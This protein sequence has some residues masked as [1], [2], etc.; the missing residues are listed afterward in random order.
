V[1][2]GY[3]TRAAVARGLGVHSTA[4]MRWEERGYVCPRKWGRYVLYSREDA[5]VVKKLESM[6]MRIHSRSYLD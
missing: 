4:L 2:P 3:K 5:G 1:P 6:R